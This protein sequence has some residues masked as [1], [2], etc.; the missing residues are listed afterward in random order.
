MYCNIVLN[1]YGRTI[2]SRGTGGGGG[3]GGCAPRWKIMEP[4]VTTESGQQVWQMGQLSEQQEVLLLLLDGMLVHHTRQHFTR[5]IC[6]CS[7]LLLG[8]KRHCESNV[9]CPRIQHNNPSQG[10][11]PDPLRVQ[12][13]ADHATTNLMGAFL[14]YNLATYYS[15]CRLNIQFNSVL[16]QRRKYYSSLVYT[17]QRCKNIVLELNLCSF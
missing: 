15:Q 16:M 5:T 1:K 7:F 17:L 6:W 9:S 10:L 2:D 12:C 14:C 8:G 13:S 3:G 4:L 11:N